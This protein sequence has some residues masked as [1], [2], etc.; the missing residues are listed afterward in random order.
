M[1][2]KELIIGDSNRGVIIRLR[3][4]EIV[5]NLCFVFK[6]EF[7]NVKEVLTDEFWINVMYEEVCVEQLKGFADSIYSD[8]VYRFKKVLYGLK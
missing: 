1:Y 6:I 4:I 3:E 8:Y 7:K 5:F 2:F